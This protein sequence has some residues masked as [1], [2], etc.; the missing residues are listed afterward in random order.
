MVSNDGVYLKLQATKDQDGKNIFKELDFNPKDFHGVQIGLGYGDE[1]LP[2]ELCDLVERDSNLAEMYSA[3]GMYQQQALLLAVQR[4]TMNNPVSFK[5]GVLFCNGDY[6]ERSADTPDATD[7]SA[8]FKDL[9]EYHHSRVAQM[10][11]LDAIDT[12]QGK[13]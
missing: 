8:V 12:Q 2:Q 7:E 11:L 5:A 3:M 9:I 10:Y 1:P 4:Q 13:K 6:R